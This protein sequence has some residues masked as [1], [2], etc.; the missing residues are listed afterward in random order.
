MAT[1]IFDASCDYQWDGLDDQ[2][3]RVLHHNVKIL[4]REIDKMLRMRNL[5]LPAAVTDVYRVTIN[6]LIEVRNEYLGKLTGM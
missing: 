5:N 2:E 3:I 4:N 6:S 1:S